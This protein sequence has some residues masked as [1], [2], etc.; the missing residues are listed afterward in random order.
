LRIKKTILAGALALI[1]LA[2]WAQHHEFRTTYHVYD[3]EYTLV[4]KGLRSPACIDPLSVTTIELA[5]RL[6]E[7]FPDVKYCR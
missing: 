4:H 1:G 3:G 7:N 6:K 2:Y 5:R